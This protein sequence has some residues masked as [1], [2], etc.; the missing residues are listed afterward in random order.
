MQLRTSLNLDLKKSMVGVKILPSLNEYANLIS[1]YENNLYFL[2][3]EDTRYERRN[4][5]NRA[6]R[7]PNAIEIDAIENSYAPMGSVERERRRKEYLC[8]KCGSSKYISL[9][10]KVP[11]PTA[12]IRTASLERIR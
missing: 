9:G 12:R 11:M 3:S 7:D 1:S 4:Y 6:L 8:F 5:T 2:R 10:C